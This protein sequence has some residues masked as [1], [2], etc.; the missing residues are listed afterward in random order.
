MSD[1]INTDKQDNDY[2][3]WLTSQYFG[4]QKQLYNY[5][6]YEEDWVVIPLNDSRKYYWSLIGDPAQSVIFAKSKER[7]FD[8]SGNH[9]ENSIYTQR[10]LK[11]WVYRGEKLT[12][13]CADTHT[14]GNKFLQIFDNSKEVFDE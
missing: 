12:M 6:G 10:F 13:V 8:E 5:F 14:D 7:L 3:N 9:Y 4:I 1:S 11:K 2:G